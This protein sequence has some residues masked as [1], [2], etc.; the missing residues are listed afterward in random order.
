MQQVQ[1]LHTHT[2]T[3]SAHPG[4]QLIFLNIESIASSL[5]IDTSTPSLRT[6]NSLCMA[7]ASLPSPRHPDSLLAIY[8]VDSEVSLFLSLFNVLNSSATCSIFASEPFLLMLRIKEIENI[9]EH[10][11]KGTN[12]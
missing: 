1:D 5:K 6:L 3:P 10:E 2:H 12:A 9:K 8:S 11:R 4:I 7:S